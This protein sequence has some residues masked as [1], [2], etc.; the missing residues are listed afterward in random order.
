MKL[1]PIEEAPRDGTPELG[2]F[3]NTVRWKPYKKHSEQYRR[4]WVGR[5]QKA[6]GY[7]GWDNCDA[8]QFFSVEPPT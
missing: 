7:G 1:H 5:W 4:G 8:P 3:T 6:N 2:E